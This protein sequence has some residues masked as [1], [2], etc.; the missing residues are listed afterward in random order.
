[1]AVQAPIDRGLHGLPTRGV[2]HFVV[3]EIACS[4]NADY[5]STNIRGAVVLI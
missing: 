1:M 4:Q 3:C 2:Y 5:S